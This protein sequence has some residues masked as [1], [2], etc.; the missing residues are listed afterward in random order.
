ML[1]LPGDGTEELKA[2]RAR[3]N[4]ALCIIGLVGSDEAW[5]L[6]NGKLI[7]SKLSPDTLLKLRKQPPIDSTRA[8][9]G[10]APQ[11]LFREP[12]MSPPVKMYP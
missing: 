6:K 2:T 4:K 9:R 12:P 3:K 8:R 11:A 5:C 1:P 10:D 7:I